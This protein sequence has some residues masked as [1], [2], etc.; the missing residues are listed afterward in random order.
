MSISE[1]YLN[2]FPAIFNGDLIWKLVQKCVQQADTV[3]LLSL[4]QSVLG[5][6]QINSKSYYPRNYQEKTQSKDQIAQKF[7]LLPNKQ[8]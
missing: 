1:R 7:F 6:A 4:W 2:V 5:S 8:I 3:V